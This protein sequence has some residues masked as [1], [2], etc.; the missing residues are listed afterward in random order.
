MSD[1]NKQVAQRIYDEVFNEGKL[2][3]ID[4]IVAPNCVEHTPPP[5]F[6]TS[7]VP[8]ALKEFT[9]ALR[10]G[11][12]DVHFSVGQMLGE[13]DLVAAYYT[14]DGTH[15]GEL[16][17]VPPSGERISFEGLDMIRIVDGKGTDHWGFDNLMLRLTG[18]AP[19]A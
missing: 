4:E 5:G 14:V 16:F 10:A 2:D 11:I 19:P 6:D 1:E 17:G 7:D 3:V 15:D 12:P 9:Q 8:K 18:G 13:D